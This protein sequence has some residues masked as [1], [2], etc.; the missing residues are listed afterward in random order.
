VQRSNQTFED[1][2]VGVGEMEP[3]FI[4]PTWAA[5]VRSG[6]ADEEP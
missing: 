1:I 6:N 5:V 3:D 2:F 4:K